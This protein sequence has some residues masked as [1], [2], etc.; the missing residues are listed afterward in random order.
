MP[1][2]VDLDKIAQ[3]NA[4]RCYRSFRRMADDAFR[5]NDLDAAKQADA[6]ADALAARWLNYRV[7]L[8][9]VVKTLPPVNA[10]EVAAI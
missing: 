1:E 10:L 7:R 6:E 3:R 8:D 2:V 5:V 4:A 9:D